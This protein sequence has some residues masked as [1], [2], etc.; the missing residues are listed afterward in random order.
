MEVGEGVHWSK[1]ADAGFLRYARDMKFPNFPEQPAFYE[2]SIGAWD[3]KNDNNAIGLA[4]GIRHYWDN[5]H[6]EA[7]GGPAWA[8]HKTHVSATHEQFV[9][10]IG[11]VFTVDRF[12]FGIFQSHYSNAK[13][14]LGWDG[15]NTG[16][17]FLTFQV[18]YLLK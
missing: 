18:G 16:Y 6:L 2:F 7:S 1:G 3:K 8:E 5:F 17:D 9:L 13:P 15:R 10:H 12:E 11:G 4:I 14:L